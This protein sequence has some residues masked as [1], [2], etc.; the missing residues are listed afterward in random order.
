MKKV[1]HK[2][3]KRSCNQSL[4]LLHLE[5][6]K[7]YRW[8]QCQTHHIHMS[9]ILNV[10]KK[11]IHIIFDL[12]DTIYLE[13]ESY[14]QWNEK[15]ERNQRKPFFANIDKPF[16]DWQSHKKKHATR[17]L[18]SRSWF[19]RGDMRNLNI[20]STQ[21]RISQKTQISFLDKVQRLKMFRI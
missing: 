15:K 14:Y 2:K 13:N 17:S 5:F 6:S 12:E 10:F 21:D 19:V 9:N 4:V 11:Y 8:W 7:L 1:K 16:H 20:S 18:K 3:R